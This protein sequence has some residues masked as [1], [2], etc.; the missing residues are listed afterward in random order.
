MPDAERLADQL[1]R[2]AETP[3]TQWVCN[4]DTLL[5]RAARLIRRQAKRIESLEAKIDRR[6]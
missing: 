1:Q 2:L 3:G 6:A 5:M 4:I